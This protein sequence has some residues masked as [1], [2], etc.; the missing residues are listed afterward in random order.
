MNFRFIAS[1]LV[2]A[3]LFVSASAPAAEASQAADAVPVSAVAQ[4]EKTL[5]AMFDFADQN[6]DGQ[7]TRDE[8]RGHL[9]ITF[10]SFGRIDTAQRGWISY[11]QFVTF[12]T[13]RVGKDAD[14]LLKIGQWH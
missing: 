5:R 8:A 10:K 11:E 14:A 13:Q 4:D 12:T 9:P 6:K 2:S 1:A 7:L 3:G